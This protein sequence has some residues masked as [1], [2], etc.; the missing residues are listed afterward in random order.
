MFKTW[1]RTIQTRALAQV[2]VYG[3]HVD[4]EELPVL[5]LVVVRRPKIQKCSSGLVVTPLGR[6]N[7]CGVE[8][9]EKH[10]GKDRRPDSWGNGGFPWALT[11]NEGF[12]SV[13]YMHM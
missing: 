1:Y 11:G 5:V 7:E 2:R 3:L 6:E 12:G 10:R 4:L 13:L 9:G 8:G